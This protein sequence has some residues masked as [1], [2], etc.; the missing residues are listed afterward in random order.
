MKII[1]SRLNDPAPRTAVLV[2]LAGAILLFSGCAA[3]LFTPLQ[4]PPAGYAASTYDYLAVEVT[5]EPGIEV[6]PADKGQLTQAIIGQAKI[7]ALGAFKGFNPAEPG[8][9][10]LELNVV[11]TRFDKGNAFAR[12][13]LAGLG[14]IH[15]DALVTVKDKDTGAILGK[16]EVKRTFAGGGLIGAGTGVDNIEVTFAQGVI[17]GV[18]DKKGK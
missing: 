2:V 13:M 11:M 17:A 4:T 5:G 15:V 16:Y 7:A 9:K 8:P 18:A 12:L 1:Q 10:T 14:Q 6:L 3:P